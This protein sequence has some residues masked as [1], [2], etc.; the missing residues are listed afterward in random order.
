MIARTAEDDTVGEAIAHAQGT[1]TAREEWRAYWPLVLACTAG[2]TM[3]VVAYVTLGLFLTPLSQEFGWSR[4]LITAGTG[5]VAVL[6][7]LAAPFV[8]A[9][10]DK[11]GARRI[12]VP[13]LVLMGLSIA[14]FSLANGLPAQWFGLWSVYA[15]ISLLLKY[16][17]WMSVIVHAFDKG[18]SLALAIILCGPAAGSALAPPLAQFLIDGYGWRTAYVTLGLGWMVPT[19][20]LAFLFIRDVRP[21]RETPSSAE[22]RAEGPGRESMNA[23]LPGLSIHDALRSTSLW[24][25]ALATLITLLISAVLLIHKVPILE[26]AGVSRRNAALLA[27]LSGVAAMAGTLSTGWLMQR[28]HPGV[29]GAITNFVL[30]AALI[31]LLDQFSTPLSIVISMLFVGFAGGTK[32]QVC[33]YLTS[34]YGGLRNFGKIY[35]VMS[36]IVAVC[37]ASGGVLGGFVY[38]LTGSYEAFILAG[39]P[40]ACISGLLLLGL[41]PVPDWRRPRQANP[42]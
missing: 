10:I 42:A 11:W 36:S 37:S 12:L 29:I 23:G 6:T 16:T 25:I 4:A 1:M 2:M 5:I 24:R 40:A 30:A 33:S 19:W 8:G 39:I 14:S 31:P 21:G 15:V 28:F 7:V 13:G 18:R 9:A 35:G 41:G 3:P 26:L 32:A 17:A 22:R 34:A 20:L 38:D 27:G